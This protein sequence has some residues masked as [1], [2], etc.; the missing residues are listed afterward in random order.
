MKDLCRFEHILTETTPNDVQFAILCSFYDGS[1]SRFWLKQ[2]LSIQA[3]KLILK[4]IEE[5]PSHH[6]EYHS[7]N[8]K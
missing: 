8:P 1:F 7:H 6:Q 4:G 2:S 5:I 3:Y